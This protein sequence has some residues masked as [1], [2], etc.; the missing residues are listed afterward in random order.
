MS[1]Y[2]FEF[3]VSLFLS[4]FL[5]NLSFFFF[6]N[7]ISK[8]QVHIYKFVVI[9]LFASFIFIASN[10]FSNAFFKTFVSLSFFT[11]AIFYFYKCSFI[12]SLLKSTIWLIFLSLASSFIG[13]LFI[14]IFSVN[15]E[16]ITSEA[17]YCSAY[18]STLV[19]FI[20]FSTLLLKPLKYN[21]FLLSK[22]IIKKNNH[23]FIILFL[24]FMAISIA[25]NSFLTMQFVDN[26]LYFSMNIILMIV[27]LLIV[28]TYIYT[29]RM[30]ESKS[31]ELE[32]IEDDYNNLKLYTEI[33]ENLMDE[34]RLFRHDH[35][36][37][38]Y[39]LSGYAKDGDYNGLNNLLDSQINSISTK[40]TSQIQ[41][42][43]KIKDA[44]LKGLLTTKI[45]KM[46]DSK[47][48]VD[49]FILDNIDYLNT[50]IM[51]FCRIVGILLDNALEAA[52]KSDQK[53]IE[54]SLMIQNKNFNILIANSFNGKIDI[55]RLSEKGYSSKGEN[56]GLGLYSAKLL[57]S[58]MPELNLSTIVDQ[59]LFMQDLTL[60]NI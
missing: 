53:K 8:T 14:Y 54:I 55:D 27:Y 46:L 44:G 12:N 35:N 30:W 15:V 49:V 18:N 16:Q 17:F 31:E 32:R 9:S 28:I 5:L 24:I 41:S 4:A 37:L 40:H 57:L 20:L 3:L 59:N 52:V 39:T 48:N 25:F 29:N 60:V 23:F 56:R 45:S 11:F 22:L 47:L 38:L 58:E 26:R 21:I 51:N 34:L 42:L 36:N 7:Q 50:D 43:S 10:I 33:M 6:M 13:I 19:V 2:S 1:N